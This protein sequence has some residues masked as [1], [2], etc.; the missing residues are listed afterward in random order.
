MKD[1]AARLLLATP[2]TED[3]AGDDSEIVLK[4][5][6]RR[7]VGKRGSQIV[8][9]HPDSKRPRD[10]AFHSAPKCVGE[11][12]HGSTEVIGSFDRNRAVHQTDAGQSV[13]EDP[14]ISKIHGIEHGTD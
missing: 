14:S 7:G 8:N 10:R 11:S 5:H 2:E 4:L 13:H 12:S 6:R 3:D 9:A 1:G